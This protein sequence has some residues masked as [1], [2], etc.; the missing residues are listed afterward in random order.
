MLR[1]V[2]SPVLFSAA[3]AIVAVGLALGAGSKTEAPRR[4]KV[5]LSHACREGEKWAI[6]DHDELSVTLQCVEDEDYEGE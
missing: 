4:E 5:W 6:V 2:I 1:S 3:F